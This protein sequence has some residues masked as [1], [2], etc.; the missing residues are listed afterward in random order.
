MK[1]GSLYL[2]EPSG[3]HRA[4]YGTP[5]PLPLK[6]RTRVAKDEEIF[7]RCTAQMTTY[8]SKFARDI[9]CISNVNAFKH[10]NSWSVHMNKWSTAWQFI[11]VFF[12]CLVQQHNNRTGFHYNTDDIL[13]YR[14]HIVSSLGETWRA[15]LA[16]AIT[17][18]HL[19]LSTVYTTYLSCVSSHFSMNCPI[20]T[21]PYEL[22]PL[23]HCGQ[24]Y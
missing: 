5:L 4:C 22:V 3:P 20:P 6:S 19:H 8:Y 15:W 23:L 21:D 24:G 13:G 14:S 9:Y 11:W 12:V 18:K 17:Q 1:S 16:P 2:L 10:Q 7:C